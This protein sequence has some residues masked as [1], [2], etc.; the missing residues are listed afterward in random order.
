MQFEWDDDKNQANIVK[1]K[2]SF[3]FAKLLFTQ[4]LVINEDKRY[5]YTEKRFIGY[6]KIDDRLMCVVYTERKPDKIR[7]ISFRKANS[8]EQKEYDNYNK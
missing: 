7:I 3:E 2:L 5:N 1:H 4:K 8:R 6:G